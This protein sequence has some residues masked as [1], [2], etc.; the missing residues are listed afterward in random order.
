MKKVSFDFDGTLHGY[1][2]GGVN[3]NEEEVRKLFVEL[4]N[5]DEF[6]VYIITRRYGPEHADKGVKNE[7]T[8][9][10]NL[11]NELKVELPEE[12]I[13]FTNRKYKYSFINNLGIDIHLDDD[14]QE[15]Q[16]IRNYSSGSSVDVQDSGWRIKFDEFL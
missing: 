6:D 14:A 11:L 3:P 10:F 4:V 9:V 16:L 12:K 15:H 7:H 13:L 5:S 2:F 8:T 1:F